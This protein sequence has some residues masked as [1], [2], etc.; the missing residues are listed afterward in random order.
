MLGE[1]HPGLALAADKIVAP[2]LELKVD[3]REI[4]PERQDLEA[5]AALLD[6]GARRAGHP[7]LVNGFESVAV[8]LERIPNRVRAVPEGRIEYRDV[9]RL[10]CRLIALEQLAHLGD[11]LGAG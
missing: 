1:S 6:A 4:A 7:V 3:R 2:H 10:E 11:D 8:L 5:D 9:L